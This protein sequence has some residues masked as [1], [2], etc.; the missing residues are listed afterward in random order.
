MNVKKIELARGYYV[1][2][3]CERTRWIANTKFLNKYS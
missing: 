2:L 1:R 3:V